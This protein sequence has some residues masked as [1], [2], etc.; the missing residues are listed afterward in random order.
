[1]WYIVVTKPKQEARAHENLENQGGE[2]FLPMLQ[3]ESIKQGKRT[4]KSEPLFPGYLFLR[5]DKNSPLFGKIRSTFGVNRLLSFGGNPVT[6]DSRLIDDLRLR[7]A[8]GD[9]LPQFKTGQT[10]ELKEGPFR[11]YQALFKEYKG[12]ERAVILLTL[13]GQQN[14]LIVELAEL[15]KR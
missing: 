2:V 3:T 15:Q 1:M 10:V 7:T 4:L 9:N 14:E 5:L 8:A 12:A 11:H 6:L 13:L